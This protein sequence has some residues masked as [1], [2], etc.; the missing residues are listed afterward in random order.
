MEIILL[1]SFMA[2][3]SNNTEL[4]IKRQPLD[5]G[6]SDFARTL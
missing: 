4:S 6:I 2:V 1:A 5:A 3:L